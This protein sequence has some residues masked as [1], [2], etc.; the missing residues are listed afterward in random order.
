MSTDYTRGEAERKER[1]RVRRKH[2]LDVLL[3]TVFPNYRRGQLT[4]AFLIRHL[5]DL[6][7]A[8]RCA[9]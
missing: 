9:K 8:Q 6:V 2:E 7:L 5:Y 3:D 4:R 1:E